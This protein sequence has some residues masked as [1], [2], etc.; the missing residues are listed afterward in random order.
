MKEST[1]FLQKLKKMSK[2]FEIN[3]KKRLKGYSICINVDVAI[4]RFICHNISDKLTWKEKKNEKKERNIISLTWPLL[5]LYHWHG[6]SLNNSLAISFDFIWKK[7]YD[8]IF[9]TV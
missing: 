5:K 8:I 4:V 6:I 2:Y 9:P 1:R 7:E 3:I